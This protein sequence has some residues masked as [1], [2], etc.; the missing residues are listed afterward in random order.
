[1]PQDVSADAVWDALRQVIDPEIGIN[2]VDLG[3]VYDVRVDGDAVT[4]DYTLTTMGCGLGPVIESE[5]FEVLRGLG[6]D[7]ARVDLVT[8]PPWSPDRISA[9]AREMLGI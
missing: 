2:I 7:N 9:E 5:I 1:V 8:V 3:L 4:V 6:A